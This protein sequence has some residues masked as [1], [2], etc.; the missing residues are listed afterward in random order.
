MKNVISD[1]VQS[2]V[3]PPKK[4][5]AITVI[6]DSSV[7][8]T[9]ILNSL[10]FDDIN[11]N[12]KQAKTIGIDRRYWRMN[13]DILIK[14][15]EVGHFDN[16]HN[17]GTFINL[18]NFSL[19]IILVVDYSSPSSAQSLIYYEKYFQNNKLL[20][21]FNKD[22]KPKMLNENSE[23]IKRL[24]E[25]YKIDKIFSTSSFNKES[26][27]SFKT[28]LTNYIEQY[29]KELSIEELSKKESFFNSN[30]DLKYYQSEN[31]KKTIGCF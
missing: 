4:K 1:I 27:L 12:E 13:N 11:E 23:S 25:I 7:G 19:L 30:P 24:Q 15:Y 28:N 16:I 18:S 3:V 22:D 17:E 8:K 29:I 5:I 14:F 31:K 2:V 6:G 20:L 26:I 21:V 10:I 9:S